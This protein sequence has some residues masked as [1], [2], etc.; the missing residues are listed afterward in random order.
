MR[1]EPT[2]KINSMRLFATLQSQLHSLIFAQPPDKHSRSVSTTASTMSNSN[3][4]R[5]RT[6]FQQ[7]VLYINIPLAVAFFATTMLHP[8]AYDTI[9]PQPICNIL[10]FP[11]VTVIYYLVSMF[12][13]PFVALEH[14]RWS[15]CASQNRPFRSILQPPRFKTR[16]VQCIFYVNM[17]SAVMFWA[18]TMLHP[19]SYEVLLPEIVYSNLPWPAVSV[20]YFLLSIFVLPFAALEYERR[21]CLRVERTRKVRAEIAV[22]SR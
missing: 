9:L 21:Y 17:P 1:C 19:S 20:A 4:M 22:D 14:E 2:L 6:R 12:I 18:V 10:P 11:Q 13:L 7:F 8:A 3:T 16:V 5:A 15:I